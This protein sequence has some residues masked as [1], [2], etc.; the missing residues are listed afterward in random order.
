MRLGYAST[1]PQNAIKRNLLP[2]PFSIFSPARIPVSTLRVVIEGV[3]LVADVSATFC[4]EEH[5]RYFWIR[6]IFLKV[7]TSFLVFMGGVDVC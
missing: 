6:V 3:A 7:L 1:Y 4:G 5:V 2:C